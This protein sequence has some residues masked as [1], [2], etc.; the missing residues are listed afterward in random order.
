[1]G[2]QQ[3]FM[4]ANA[5]LSVEMEEE[6]PSSKFS[7]RLHPEP[8]HRR[9]PGRLTKIVPRKPNTILSRHKAQT[10]GPG[11]PYSSVAGGS[12]TNYKLDPLP[13]TKHKHCHLLPGPPGGGRRGAALRLK[14]LS[15]RND[16]QIVRGERIERLASRQSV[17]TA[18]SRVA[19]GRTFSA[20]TISLP[21]SPL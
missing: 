11:A 3:R 8:K 15:T 2:H 13:R 10:C 9:R 6:I 16:I 17:V 7:R 4:S 12:R 19:V 20:G 14:D 1:M 18:S 21:S 5:L